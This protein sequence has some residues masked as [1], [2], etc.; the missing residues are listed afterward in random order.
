LEE[1]ESGVVVVKFQNRISRRAPNVN[2]KALLPTVGPSGVAVL[3]ERPAIER[4]FPSDCELDLLFCELPRPVIDVHGQISMDDRLLYYWV[5][6]CFYQGWGTII[7]AGALVGGTTTALSEGLMRNDRVRSLDR[8]IYVY[9]LFVDSEDGYS[10]Q[11]IRNWYSEERIAGEYDF[12]PHFCKN[13]ERYSH[14]LSVHKGDVSAGDYEDP[15]G[16]EV[17]SIDVAKTPDLMIA[18]AAKFF[19][20]LVPN[21]SIVIHQDY[22]FAMQPWLILA[23]ELLS[24]YFERVYDVPTQASS[25][26]VCRKE[27]GEADVYR[28]LGRQSKSYYNIQNIELIYRA[29][30]RCERVR[31]KIHMLTAAVYLLAT[32]GEMG[33]ARNLMRRIVEE[34]DVSR[35]LAQNSEIEILLKSELGMSLDF[36]A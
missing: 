33:A 7:D 5:G 28:I 18:V 17:L 8:P 22:V 35:R 15:R 2:L 23:M 20:K 13:T 27:I 21:K 3:A 1:Y 6:R 19:K 25:I 29:A 12:Y 24:E 34:F 14:L 36:L 9:D 16:I 26:F 32:F 31:G 10:A 4:F 30:N 11:S